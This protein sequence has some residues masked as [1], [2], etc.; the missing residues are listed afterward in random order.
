MENGRYYIGTD[1]KFQITL[2]AEGFDQDTDRY[3]VQ[4]ICGS[5]SHTYSSE[6][7]DFATGA[8]GNHYLLI[9]TSNLNPGVMKMVITAYVPDLDFD[10]HVRK[11][12]ESITLGPIRPAI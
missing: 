8:D 2:T 10:A 11:E 12:V 3:D 5:Y 7:G 4:F 9:P 6:N 1:L